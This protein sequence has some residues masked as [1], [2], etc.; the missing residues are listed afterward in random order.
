[1]LKPLFLSLAALAGTAVPALATHAV[2]ST[3]PDFTCT[4]VYGNTVNLYE[5]R[6]KVVLINFGATW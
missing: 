1:M 3:P 2:G 5:Q 4:D 6:G